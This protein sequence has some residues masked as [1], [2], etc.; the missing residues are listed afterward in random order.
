MRDRTSRRYRKREV[1]TF[2]RG[3]PPAR[4][5]REDV[6][7][8]AGVSATVV[9]YVLNRGPRPVADAT[10][11]RVLKSIETLQFRPNTLARALRTQRS[12]SIGL[13]VPD[14]SNPFF[15]E[16]AKA[17]EDAAY[18]RGYALLLGNF[19]E[20]P[21]RESSQLAALRD[22]QVDGLLIIGASG[23]SAVDA[24]SGGPP[25]ILL[26]RAHSGAPF[27]TV[28][29]D[30]EEAAYVGV[31]HLIDHGHSTVFCIAGPPTIRAASDRV[32]G[33]KMAMHDAGLSTAGLL[34]SGPFTRQFGYDIAKTILADART[35]CAIFASSDLQGAAVL[36]CCY[37]LGLRV[38]EDVA[39]VAFDGTQE[40]E[41]T[42]PPMT[43][44]RQ[45]IGSIAETAVAML[46]DSHQSAT[47]MHI[48]APYEL[49]PRRSCG[50]QE[51][52]D[53]LN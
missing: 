19:S 31:T 30:N 13:L 34:Y 46:L 3:P 37:E 5:T 53:V 16:L 22:R 41:F 6:A 50:C 14:N 23:E 52:R 25:I 18:A 33:W 49:V 2:M 44:V 15:A 32:R 7:R 51:V 10:R 21:E 43:A 45:N 24:H 17:V 12:Q 9:S 47:P 29:I 11:L 20:D 27:S 39:L 4:V 8:H 1:M 42:S 35:P 48:V 26:D 38:P 40:S 28:V 36:R